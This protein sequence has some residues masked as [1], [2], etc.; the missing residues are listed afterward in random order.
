[1]AVVGIDTLISVLTDLDSWHRACAIGEAEM[2]FCIVHDDDGRWRVFWMERGNRLQETEFADEQD[3]CLEFMGRAAGRG[4]VVEWLD[5][6]GRSDLIDRMH[7]T[8]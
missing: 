4:K 1:M 2:C 7:P 3:A 8:L 5:Q 6:L